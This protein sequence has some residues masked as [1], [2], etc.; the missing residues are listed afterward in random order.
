[1]RP[2]YFFTSQ[3]F[4]N[5]F[6]HKLHTLRLLEVSKLISDIDTLYAT[7]PT[8][9]LHNERIMH[10]PEFDLLST[11]QAEQTLLKARQLVYEYGDK[12]SKALAHQQRHT[13]ANHMIDQVNSDSGVLLDQTEINN[14]FSTLYKLFIHLNSPLAWR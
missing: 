8:P 5:A 1:M 11:G 7:A 9:E 10:T 2:D 6:L 14:R 12:T 3:V 13:F 4:F